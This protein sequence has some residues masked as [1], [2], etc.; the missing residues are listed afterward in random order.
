MFMLLALAWKRTIQNN[1]LGT[2]AI[3]GRVGIFGVAQDGLEVCTWTAA[4]ILV[5]TVEFALWHTRR[6]G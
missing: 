3:S 6:H 1:Q 2:F 5:I 4:C